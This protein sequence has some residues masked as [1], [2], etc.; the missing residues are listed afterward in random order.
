MI[1][2]IWNDQPQFLQ[3]DKIAVSLGGQNQPL[4]VVEHA[5]TVSPLVHLL[6]RRY[7]CGL[8]T[9]AFG[10]PRKGRIDLVL[11]IS[12]SHQALRQRIY[13]I[14]TA[15]LLIILADQ[16]DQNLQYP[17]LHLFPSL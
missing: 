6:V 15:L 4:D 14:K 10:K 7:G 11:R 5:M 1:A 9:Q 8:R 2:S 13:I 17:F 12:Q 16:I 3:L